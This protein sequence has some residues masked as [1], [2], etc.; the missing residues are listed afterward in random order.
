MLT[1]DEVKSFIRAVRIEMDARYNSKFAQAS[2][3]ALVKSDLSSLEDKVDNINTDNSNYVEKEDG[4]TLSS[5]DFTDADKQAL[6]ELANNSSFDAS[7]VL[8]IFAD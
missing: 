7:D 1:K 3:L 6:D 4:K 5:N 8:D 2:S